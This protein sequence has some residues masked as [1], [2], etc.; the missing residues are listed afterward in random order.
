MTPFAR[1]VSA[2]KNVGSTAPHPQAI[3]RPRLGEASIGAP[4]LVCTHY[5]LAEVPEGH[6][7]IHGNAHGTPPG[8]SAHI[9]VAVEQLDYEPVGLDRLR[10]LARALVAGH[11]PPGATTL[12]RIALLEQ[13][14]DEG[15][16]NRRRR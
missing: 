3:C 15:T 4:P 8:G 10:R 2:Y 14:A 6:V 1:E 9:N 11:Y 16:T 13:G 7:N 12:E 5:P